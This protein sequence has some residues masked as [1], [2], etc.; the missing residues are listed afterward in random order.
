MAQNAVTCPTCG[1]EEAFDVHGERP[2]PLHEIGEFRCNACGTRVVYGQIVPPIVIEPCRGG[3]DFMWIRCRIQDPKTREDKYV[4]DID[5]KMA[6]AL[7]SDILALVK[8]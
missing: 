1:V 6:I 5:P 7:T 4:V 8:R 2:P 3:G